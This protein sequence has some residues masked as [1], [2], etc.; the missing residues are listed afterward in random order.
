[1]LLLLLPIGVDTLLFKTVLTTIYQLPGSVIYK[2][3]IMD[4]PLLDRVRLH[5]NMLLHTLVYM[6]LSYFSKEIANIWTNS[7]VY[8]CHVTKLKVTNMNYAPLQEIGS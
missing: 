7:Y 2:T 4:S 5:S 6:L 3:P 8:L 1:M